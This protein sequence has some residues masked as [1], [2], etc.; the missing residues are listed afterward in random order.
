M[1]ASLRSWHD[2]QVPLNSPAAPRPHRAVGRGAL[3]FV[4]LAV[5]LAS[6]SAN[7][8]VADQGVQSGAVAAVGASSASAGGSLGSSQQARQ[9]FAVAE[10]EVLE[11]LELLTELATH[12]SECRAALS[13]ARTAAS[14]RLEATGGVWTA[15][16]ESTTPPPYT[17]EGL[18]AYMAAGAETELT[19]LAAA[20]SIAPG[21][22][23][24]L[25]GL[26]AGRLVSARLLGEAFQV[27]VEQAI[28][29]LPPSAV[30]PFEVTETGTPT[31]QELREDLAEEALISYDCVA[32]TLVRSLPAG[33]N[34]E[35]ALD[36]D[37]GLSEDVQDRTLA[38]VSTG[39][40][41]D[42]QVRCNLVDSDRAALM[43]ELLRADLLLFG[44]G[45]RAA[46]ALGAQWVV[47]DAS[48]LAASAPP[49]ALTITLLEQVKDLGND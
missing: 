28:E 5:A 36:A 4:A 11:R 7:A 35:H 8:N 45:N 18:V 14:A 24:T 41:D 23:T 32:Q 9:L 20:E 48:A 34:R 43:G 12:C 29:T 21:E 10:A 2:R 13:A 37:L 26:A 46:R 15:S 47:A 31:E 16:Q 6:C 17:V 30:P 3:V 39:V 40:R 25:A 38:L 22:R 49:S 44:S 42:R 27:D 33:G 19:G 1:L